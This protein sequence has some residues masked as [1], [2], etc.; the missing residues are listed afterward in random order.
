M[1]KLQGLTLG[2]PAAERDTG[3]LDYFVQSETYKALETGRASVL[4]G[5]RGSDKSAIF[6]YLAD[7]ERRAGTHVIEVSPDNYSYEMLKDVLA[8]ELD[9]HW[10]KQNA[11]SVSWKYVIHVM[12][13]K[14]VAKSHFGSNQA[15][16]QVQRFLHDNFTGHQDGPVD[17]LIFL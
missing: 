7:K 12:T 17:A 4:I 10:A 16:K 13:L 3:L 8:R 14:A 6:R 2:A 1:G 11:Y 15:R 9:G 5:N